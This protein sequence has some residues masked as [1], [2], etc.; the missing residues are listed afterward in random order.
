MKK[1]RLLKPAMYIAVLAAAIIMAACS[2][3]GTKSNTDA[4]SAEG[5]TSAKA[6][7]ENSD[8]ASSDSAK[9]T[10]QES[11]SA[12]NSSDKSEAQAVNKG[13]LAPDFDLTDLDGNKFKLS[14]QRGKKV[15]IKFWASW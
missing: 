9:T 14:E 4:S 8:S 7:S 1:K 6:A 5:S 11:A 3:N 12:A 15:Y 13:E 10:A 2:Q